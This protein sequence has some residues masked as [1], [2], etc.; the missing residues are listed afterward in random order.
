MRCVIEY[1][2]FG[3]ETTFFPFSDFCLPNYGT[4]SPR[5]RALIDA[6]HLQRIVISQDICTRT[7]LLT[8]GGHGYGHILKNVVPLMRREGI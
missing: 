6:G 1:D 8:F 5:F 4:L 2:L 3:I 7:R